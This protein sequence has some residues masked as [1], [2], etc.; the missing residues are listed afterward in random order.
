MKIIALVA[1]V[2]P[3][4]LPRLQRMRR[5]FRPGSGSDLILPIDFRAHQLHETARVVDLRLVDPA[6]PLRAAAHEQPASSL[7]RLRD[8]AAGRAGADH[9]V[10]ERSW[11]GSMLSHLGSYD[12][13][14]INGISDRDE[15]PTRSRQASIGAS[16][17]V[18]LVGG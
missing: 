14:Q 18:A 9:D 11:A 1:L 8:D 10:V 3:S 13:A 17:V 6:R 12:V 4:V 2:P 5:P 16:F 7:N 15:L